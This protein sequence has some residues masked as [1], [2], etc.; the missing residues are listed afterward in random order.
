MFWNKK[1]QKS[2]FYEVD[3]SRS[4][5]NDFALRSTIFYE[6]YR[7]VEYRLYYKLMDEFMRPRLDDHLNK[8]FAGN[9]D[10]A[11]GDMLI[12]VLFGDAREAFPDLG[13]Q[14]CNHEDTIRRLITRRDAD[15]KDIQRIRDERAAELEE[16]SEEF[17]KAREAL[18]KYEEA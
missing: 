5:V 6:S 12:G 1:K 13:L 2:L 18:R 4:E 11:N 9:V 7:P 3:N 8:L 16:I 10:E 14:H 15:Y 17:E